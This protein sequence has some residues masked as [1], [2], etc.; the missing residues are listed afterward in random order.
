[1]SRV[2]Q[3]M[4]LYNKNRLYDAEKLYNSNEELKNSSQIMFSEGCLIGNLDF[5]QWFYEI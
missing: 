5:I 3:F 2:I 4:S 1:M